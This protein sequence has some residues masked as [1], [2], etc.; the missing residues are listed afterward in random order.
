MTRKAEATMAEAR[1]VNPEAD[2][3]EF[4]DR[5]DREQGA[6]NW[7]A[8]APLWKDL[9]SKLSVYNS[10]S[11]IGAN[12]SSD[13]WLVAVD[14]ASEGIAG[15][16]DARLRDP[17]DPSMLVYLSEAYA[18]TGRVEEALAQ[19]ERGLQV[20]P[21]ELLASNQLMAAAAS[22]D[23]DRIQ[24]AWAWVMQTTGDP[25]ARSL[26]PLRDRPNEARAMLRKV[27]ADRSVSVPASR[28][29]LW[30]AY[31]GEP[32]LALEALQRDQ[33]M[34]RR[35]ITAL[36]LWRP[37]MRDVRRLPGFRDLVT[38]WGFV[39]YWRQFG[40]GDHCKPVGEVEFECR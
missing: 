27:M 26:Y 11:G 37:V 22:G 2:L 12:T 30:A 28:M 33:D 19:L 21:G 25:L 18:N 5:F 20:V 38:D 13:Q 17:L 40:W 39:D 36:A 4:V 7:A 34:V 3:L 9:D 29:A 23:A 10:I 15:L 1:R 16:E 8:M 35:R 32:E 24:A 14:K 31:F 6:G